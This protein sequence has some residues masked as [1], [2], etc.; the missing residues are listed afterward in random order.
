MRSLFKHFIAL[1]LL[2]FFLCYLS[3]AQ[4][5]S[6]I[7]FDDIEFVDGSAGSEDD[8]LLEVPDDL[9]FGEGTTDGEMEA[10]A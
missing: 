3:F 8:T 5:D 10:D 9:M 7:S 4:Q 6:L 1:Q 2:A